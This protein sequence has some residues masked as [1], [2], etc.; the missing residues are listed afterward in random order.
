M[1]T[2]EMNKL[3]TEFYKSSLK[4]IP[5]NSSILNMGSGLVFN[6]EKIVTAEKY[7]IVTSLDIMPLKNKPDFI[8]E[9]IVQNIEEPFQLRRSFD[10]VTAFEV[11]EHLDMTDIFITNCYANLRDNGILILSFPNLSSIF[12]RIELLLGYQPHTLEISNILSTFGTG[13]F[14]KIANADNRSIHHVRG[15]THK[16]MRDFLTFHGFKIIKTT[17]F[18]WRFKTFFSFYPSL[19]PVNIFICQKL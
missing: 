11:I 9:Y 19:S 16:A 10:I 13:I 14:G 5:K 1:N 6:F 17:G 8:K 7:A 15:I 2:G 18:D 12:S 3:D 4:Y